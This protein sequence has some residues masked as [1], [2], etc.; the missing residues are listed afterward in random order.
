MKPILTFRLLRLALPLFLVTCT[1]VSGDDPLKNTKK[2]VAKGHGSLYE[3]GAFEVPYTSI[4]LI[5]PGPT[6]EDLLMEM[7]GVNARK[8][9]LAG[10]GSAMEATEI[11]SEGT[12][13]SYRLAKTINQETAKIVG[14]VHHF[15]REGSTLIAYKTHL[16]GKGIEGKAWKVSDEVQSALE[17]L[18]DKTV[19]V[20]REIGDQISQSGADWF[21]GSPALASAIL[22]SGLSASDQTEITMD[23]S[24]RAMSESITLKGDNIILS[25]SSDLYNISDR[26]GDTYDSFSMSAEKSTQSMKKFGEGTSKSSQETG[27]KLMDSGVDLIQGSLETGVHVYQKTSEF[28]DKTGTSFRQSADNFSKKTSESGEGIAQRSTKRGVERIG[29]TASNVGKDF[30]QSMNES[31]SRFGQS[32][33]SFVLGYSAIPKTLS[34]RWEDS[35]VEKNVEIFSK[36]K[37]SYSKWREE[38]SDEYATVITE[39][40]GNYGENVSASFR[41]A[42]EIYDETVTENGFSLAA[43]KAMRWVIQGVFWDGLIKPTGK[44]GGAMLGYIGVNG[45]AYPTMVTLNGAKSTVNIAV[46]VTLNTLGTGYDLVAP[47]G[48]A[49]L[50]GTLGVA[51]AIGGSAKAAAVGT[52]GIL[53]GAGDVALGNI[54]GA[55]V[56]GSGATGSAAL[57]YIVVPAAQAGIHVAGGVAGVVTGS[58][59]ATVGVGIAAAGEALK[60]GGAVTGLAVKGAAPIVSGAMKVTGGAASLG[61]GVMEVLSGVTLYA[62]GGVLKGTA[63]VLENGIKYGA[64]P[65]AKGTV[66]TGGTVAGVSSGVGSAIVGGTTYLW[67]QVV[68]GSG[69]AV[70]KGIK[71]AIAPV[72]MAGIA[73]A[74]TTTRTAVEA[75][76]GITA[77]TMA[78]ATEAGSGIT[79]VFGN[80]I[81][82][83]TVAGG[84]AASAGAGVA[85]GLYEVAK[86]ITVPVGYIGGAGIVLSYQSISHIAAHSVLAVAD[87]SYLVLS[88]EGPRWVVYAVQGKLGNGEDLKPG[89]VLDLKKMQEKGETFYNVPVADGEMK[90]IVNTTYTTLPTPV[91]DQP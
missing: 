12:Q 68:K 32:A 76:G 49:A 55:I 20:S 36:K 64:S 22:A 7:A 26:M 27:D 37:Q 38:N 90:N 88:L 63:L 83:A 4:K 52:T 42:G 40:V 53:W 70:G 6:K 34:S 19:R 17:E 48:A 3:N 46:Q 89:A 8:S 30:N 59:I 57:H 16:V 18:G 62:T 9:F 35:G 54:T 66:V 14:S 41:K 45:V 78:L 21:Q 39:T 23:D 79:W 74:G 73:A 2:L 5:P 28:S 44:I 47:T 71:Y 61:R 72:T 77:G 80:S 87:A 31:G 33:I 69:W 11:V 43:L 24:A 50:A 29:R 51:T 10:I 1:T 86:G 75:T 84:T 67:G 65:I 91:S 13:Y 81:A 58:S 82:G 85:V 25:G 15:A 56:K 60:G